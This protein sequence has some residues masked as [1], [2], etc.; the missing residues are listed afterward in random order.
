MAIS[1]RGFLSFM[2]ILL[3]VFFFLFSPFLSFAQKDQITEMLDSLENLYFYKD[4]KIDNPV[5]DKYKPGFVPE[6]DVTTYQNRFANMAKNSPFN[7]VY[8]TTVRS[9]IDRY[10]RNPKS[11][12]T[13]LALEKLYFPLYE[14]CLNHYNIPLELKYLSIVESALN[15]T[16]KSQC[17]ASGL[18]QFMYGTGRVYNLEINSYVDERFDPEKETIA[19]C[20]YLKDLYSIYNDWSLAI[21]AYNCGPGN[22][23]KAMKRSGKKD[24][25]D[26][27]EYLPKET[28]NYV[29]AF[30]AVS[31]IMTYHEEHNMSIANIKYLYDD[32][33]SIHIN[34][35]T[36]L[37]N[38]SYLLNIPLKELKYFN[39]K[40]F[41]GVI[42]G[43]NDVVIVSKDKALEWIDYKNKYLPNDNA[44]SST[45]IKNTF[46][47]KI[48]PDPLISYPSDNSKKQKKEFDPFGTI[49]NEPQFDTIVSDNSVFQ[50]VPD[51]SE[52]K[53]ESQIFVC[54]IYGNQTVS[55]NGT[56]LI[57]NTEIINID[58]DT[59]IPI[60]SIIKGRVIFKDNSIFIKTLSAKTI[61][62]DVRFVSET[63]IREKVER[64][65]IEIEDGYTVLLKN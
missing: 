12:A 38:I 32:L 29:P 10:T 5:D 54:E 41:A 1:L 17:G 24:F 62:G 13:I 22:V 39:P 27:K 37:G 9:Y 15:P 16:A 47:K 31:Y 20:R 63:E 11:A 45:E 65:Q 51:T 56:I 48:I 60:N 28:Q 49:V 33:D 40:Y 61:Y 21:A 46:T 6:F 42:P 57:R 55:N 7:Y 59:Y 14:K 64:K 43:N 44:S 8:N 52:E 2:K 26:I 50:A 18:W 3:F 23:N 53:S 19:A 30:I 25:W 36:S 4:I 35:K 58:E 34:K